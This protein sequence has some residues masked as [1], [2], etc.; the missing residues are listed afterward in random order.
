[1]FFENVGR[2]HDYLK[3]YGAYKICCGKRL[4]PLVKHS[5]LRLC[6]LFSQSHRARAEYHGNRKKRDNNNNGFAERQ[7]AIKRREKNH[8]MHVAIENGAAET[9]KTLGC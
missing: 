2:A 3:F 1:M 8:R 9:S 5:H 6:A 7:R 4:I